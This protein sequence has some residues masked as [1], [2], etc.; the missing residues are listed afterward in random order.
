MFGNAHTVI[1]ELDC[2]LAQNVDDPLIETTAAQVPDQQVY[3]EDDIESVESV[4]SDDI[5]D[6]D[7]CVSH[8][9]QVW[10]EDSECE[11]ALL[12]KANTSH[13]LENQLKVNED[14]IVA[15]LN[16]F[17]KTHKLIE[18]QLWHEQLV[19]TQTGKEEKSS[20]AHI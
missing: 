16:H 19:K 12:Q 17:D 20:H 14:Q 3:C 5:M 1:S 11:S 18:N 6:E 10:C 15:T 4:N 9:F 2:V 8:V 7:S 13:S